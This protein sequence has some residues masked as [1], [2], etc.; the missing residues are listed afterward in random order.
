MSVVF[1]YMYMAVK[2]YCIFQSLNTLLN[3]LKVF[4]IAEI[5]GLKYS[6]QFPWNVSALKLLAYILNPNFVLPLKS[7]DYDCFVQRGSVAQSFLKNTSKQHRTFRPVLGWQ[8][9]GLPHWRHRQTLLSRWH[10][11]GRKCNF[12]YTLLLIFCKYTN[13]S[14]VD[15]SFFPAVIFH[16]CVL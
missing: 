1:A 2:L 8:T 11:P 5:S 4:F 15:H 9:S 10:A 13:F 6:L 7:M 16:Y 12:T 3:F 14:N